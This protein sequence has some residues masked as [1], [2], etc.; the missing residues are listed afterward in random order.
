MSRNLGSEV[1]L[2]T[3]MVIKVYILHVGLVTF[4]KPDAACSSLWL[5]FGRLGSQ[6]G[7]RE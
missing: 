4:I 1:D 5:Q 2:S 3:H 6:Q 7:M